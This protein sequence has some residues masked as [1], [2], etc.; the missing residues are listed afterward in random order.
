MWLS[1]MSTEPTTGIYGVD[2]LSRSKESHL[3]ASMFSLFDNSAP[4]HYY[5]QLSSGRSLLSR[6][7]LSLHPR[8]PQ[9]WAISGV[10]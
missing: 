4:S 3:S 2:S 8:G 6:V 5:S 9:D 7:L 10:E 1:A